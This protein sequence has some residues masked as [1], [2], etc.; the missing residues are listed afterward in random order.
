MATSLKVA[1]VQMVSGT[2]VAINLERAR[3]LVLQA[4]E[5]GAQIVSLPEYFCL[6]GQKDT[7]KVALAKPFGAG[8][9]QSFLAELAQAAKVWLIGG[10]IPLRASSRAKVR[11]S[12]LVVSPHGEVRARYDKVHLFGFKREAEQ[13]NESATIEAGNTPTV[14]DIDGWRVGLSVCYDL[15]FPEL[16]RALGTCDLLVAPSAFTYTTG[17]AHWELLLRTRAIENQAYMLASAQGGVHANGRR[18]WGH[19][20]L[21]DPWGEVLHVVQQGEGVVMGELSRERLT[22]VRAMLPALQH[23]RMG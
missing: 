21:V 16:Y 19:S 22:Q 14:V 6:L 9:L 5:Q 20:M 3:T 15:R 7:D 11:N 13:F 2:D 4:A 8:A 1:A 18:T 17:Q 10:T 12:L 23:R